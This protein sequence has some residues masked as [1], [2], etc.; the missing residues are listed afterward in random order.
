M[1]TSE[2]LKTYKP[3]EFNRGIEGGIDKKRATE[4]ASKIMCEGDRPS[5]EWLLTPIIV[6]GKKKSIIDGHTKI[7]ACEKVLKETEKDI[8]LIVVEKYNCPKRM[9]PWEVVGMLNSCQKPWRT[10][11]YI[12]CY[13][14]ENIEDYVKLKEAA[15][16]LGEPFTKKNGKPNYKYVCSLIGS[17]VPD[18]IMKNGLYK[19]SDVIFK[20]GQRVKE[21]F[22]QL[23]NGKVQTSAW[24]ERFIIAY[25]NLE[26]S[27][28]PDGEWLKDWCIENK[29]DF[30]FDGSTKT[31]D[32]RK[33]FAAVFQKWRL[34][35][36]SA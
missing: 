33:Q 32:W 22:D 13:V 10:E 36:V 17:T 15:Q 28:D 9:R 1:P 29:N 19:Y 3:Y 27:A 20:R 12:E 34:K 25:V 31:E 5:T 16:A 26:E 21:L 4:I 14:H 8:E 18:A 24:F 23:T 11:T 7:A 2:V 35:K 6:D 30:V